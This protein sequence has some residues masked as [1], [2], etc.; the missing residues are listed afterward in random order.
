MRS[1]IPAAVFLLMVSV[2]MSLRHRQII[3]N[4][5]RMHWTTW[6][7]LLLATFIVPAALALL[8]GRILPL[9]P[10]EMAGL[11]LVGAAPGA[12]LMTRNIAKKGFDMQLAAGYQVWGGLLTP[13][14]LPIV[15]GLAGLLYSIRIWIPPGD[16]LV[17]IVEKQFVPLVVGIL[18]AYFL[19]AFSTKAQPWMNRIGNAVLML[20]IIAILWVMRSTLAAVLTWW[21]PVAALLLAIGSIAAIR[22]LVHADDLTVRT[23]AICNANRHIGLALLLSGQYLHMKRTLPGV[24]AYAL[25]APF[26]MGVAAKFFHKGKE[27]LAEPA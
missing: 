24:A 6:L 22:L 27:S 7:G 11:F 1:I 9:K 19:P 14:V 16:M 12:P 13:I 18:L 25:V 4:L 8:I 17:Q 26:V 10:A 3:D 15:V 20:G 2:G 21:L 5:R 23:L